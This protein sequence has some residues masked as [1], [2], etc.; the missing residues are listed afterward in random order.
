MTKIKKRKRFF[1][2]MVEPVIRSSTWPQQI[3]RVNK[4]STEL[5]RQWC[6]SSAAGAVTR[7]NSH[8]AGH[9]LASSVPGARRRPDYSH[10]VLRALQHVQENFHRRVCLLESARTQPAS[11]S[12]YLLFA[13]V[14]FAS[15]STKLALFK[16]QGGPKK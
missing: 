8:A 5:R 11:V 10:V 3:Q 9:V 4:P 13:V 7:Q 6:E 2:T 14:S 12:V 1:T 16:V 15:S